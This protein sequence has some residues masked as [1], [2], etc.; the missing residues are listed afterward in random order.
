MPHSPSFIK[1]A[2]LPPFVSTVGHFEA[3]KAS[4]LQNALTPPRPRSPHE[5]FPSVESSVESSAQG[6]GRNF[7]IPP[8]GLSSDP[9]T[10]PTFRPTVEIY[11][12]N[13]KRPSVLNE[14][15]ACAE[16]ISGF[17]GDCVYVLSSE[18]YRRTPCPK[19]QAPG[20][21]YKPFQLDLR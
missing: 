11:C 21:R 3:Y 10:S 19:C 4:P 1:R 18:Q 20:P 6:S 15:Y 2:S 16:C 14:S 13:C 9:A 8:T 17:C 12:A 5:P 7:H